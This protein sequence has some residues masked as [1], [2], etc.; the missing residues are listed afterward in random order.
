MIFLE[1]SAF[2]FNGIKEQDSNDALKT[3][4]ITEF[5]KE[6]GDKKDFFERLTPAQLNRIPSF[7]DFCRDDHQVPNEVA[8][9]N[10]IAELKAKFI[11][12]P[13]ILDTKPRGASRT[14]K[15]E[16][17]SS[18]DISDFSEKPTVEQIQARV[19]SQKDFIERDD[20]IELSSQSRMNKASRV[21]NKVVAETKHI[22]KKEIESPKVKQN[23]IKK[24]MTLMNCKTPVEA[25]RLL[26]FTIQMMQRHSSIMV[27]FPTTFLNDHDFQKHR[28]KTAFEGF[29]PRGEY[30]LN[31]RK[32]R[33]DE[34]VAHTKDIT[35]LDLSRNEYARPR[36]GQLLLFGND[37][38]P[39][40]HE[41]YGD[42]YMILDEKLKLEST[43]T[44]GDTYIDKNLR[45]STIGYLELMLLDANKIDFKDIFRWAINGAVPRFY[46]G[47]KNYKSYV[48][49]QM[50]VIDILNSKY[51]KNIHVNSDSKKL[52]KEVL[53]EFEN[54]GIAIDN[55]NLESIYKIRNSFF[56]L[57][58]DKNVN[59]EEVKRL[60]ERYPYLPKLRDKDN[61][62]TL[63][64]A[65][66]SGNVEILNILVKE[67][68]GRT[69]HGW[70]GKSLGEYEKH[71]FCKLL[72]A[73]VQNSS[74][75]VAELISRNINIV[76][77]RDVHSNT[78]LMLAMIDKNEAAA[79]NLILLGDDHSLI[80]RHFLAKHSKE[81]HFKKMFKDFDSLIESAEKKFVL[82][83]KE[84]K[85]GAS[86]E[87]AVE[88]Y[89]S[90]SGNLESSASIKL[91][92]F[93]ID[94]NL[95]NIKLSFI[96]KFIALFVGKDEIKIEKLSHQIIQNLTTD[97]GF[98]KFLD[99]KKHFDKIAER[100]ADISK[101]K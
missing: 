61:I 63:E 35:K 90:K 18:S 28:L 29:N 97:P 10:Y 38:V 67:L 58:K 25:E 66:K 4:F 57:I 52:D 22:N 87:D 99:D 51:V 16:S 20:K 36:Y 70:K 60:I 2:I 54:L 73:A 95:S 85:K 34:L 32:N 23:L 84:V 56:D 64:M 15:N 82:V 75:E 40:K 6:F 9:K 27:N 11:E 100:S 68:T 93:D 81:G 42:S 31:R 62:T 53:D 101:S 79:K 86:L 44:L 74:I 71:M 19:R 45:L 69:I 39:Q 88:K 8:A 83:L 49:A 1:I 3:L 98:T 78:P 48:E 65:A 21:W 94:K 72:Y 47:D 5:Q 77:L 43:F 7:L 41:W 37:Q 33:E 55:N 12:N 91:K 17:L 80:P 13:N 50:P 92:S 26:E 89:F 24:V 96:E 14:Y 30:Y 59:P 46:T 76:D